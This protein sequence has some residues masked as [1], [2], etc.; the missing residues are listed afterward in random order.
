MINKLVSRFLPAAALVLLCGIIQVFAQSQTSTGQIT[1]VVSDGT[2]AVVPNATMTLTN[3]NT[4]KSATTT[5]N[6]T[7]IFQFVL[8]QPGTYTV[9]ASGGGFEEQTREVIVNVGRTVDVNFS[10]GVGDLT[11]VVNVTGEEIQTTRSEPDAVLNDTQISNLPINGRRFQDLATLTPTAQVDPSRGQ[12]SLSGQRGVNSNINVD[13]SDYSNPFFGGIRGGERSNSAFTVPQ[14]S[15]R[16]FNVIAAGYSA[17]FGRST[18]GVISVVTK[19][20]G[21]NLSGS[22]FYLLRPEQAARA[23]SYAKAIGDALVTQGISPGT[24]P[25][26]HQ[27][28]GSIGGPI[29]QDRVF[30]FGSYEQQKVSAPRQVLFRNALDVTPSTLTPGQRAVYDLFKSLEVPFTLTNDAIAGLGRVDA[31]INDTNTMNVRF[32]FSRNEGKNAVTTGEFDVDPTTNRSLLTNGTEKDRT[33]SLNGQLVSS[34]SATVINEFRA[35]YS[36]EVRPRLANSAVALISNTYG[37]IGTRSFMP[38]TQFDTRVQIAD[39]LTFL[40]NNHTLKAGFD[41]NR[42]HADQ[43]FGFDQFGTYSY[44]DSTDTRFL[45]VLSNIPNANALFGRFDRSNATFRQ[46]IGNLKVAYTVTEFAVFAQDSWRYNK[47]LTLNFGIRLDNQFNPTP[48]LGNTALIDAV[49]NGNYPIFAGSS[50]DPTEIPDSGLQFGPRVGFAW[51]PAGDGKTVVR[52]FSGVFYA[53]TPLLLMADPMNNFRTTPGNLTVQFPFTIPTQF[54]QAMFDAQNPGYV[55]LVGPGRSPNTVYRHFAI[56]GINLNSSPLTNMPG[57]TP[58]QL[59]TISAAILAASP[60]APTSALGFFTGAQ[61]TFMAPDF[62]NPMSL[63]FGGGVERQLSKA[64]SVGADFSQVRTTQLQRNKNINIP[65]AT[66]INAVSGRPIYNRNLR[67]VP[68]LGNISVRES[69]AQS[70]FR[71]LTLRA[72]FTN[73]W[74]RLN[75]FYVLSKSE[76]DDDNERDSGGFGYVDAFNYQPEYGPSRIDRRHQFTANP[77]FFLPYGFEISSAIKLRSGV[78]F[79]SQVGADLNSDNVNNDRPYTAFGVDLGR[80]AFRQPGVYEV[81]LRVQ[82]G[83]NFDD[84]KRLVLT[85]EFFNIFNSANIQ[86]GFNQTRYCNNS[87]AD[88]GLSG[89][90]NPNFKLIRDSSGNII[91][92]NFAGSQVFQAQFGARFQF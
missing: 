79:D 68:T 37:D 60:G 72:R 4:G 86:Y 16:E 30:Y 70:M 14:E 67:P 77:I 13:G 35:Q 59:Q 85:A 66:S 64:F 36:K 22:A 34:I 29:K 27:F 45:D 69:S 73:E 24:A 17:E 33:Y 71:A 61:P 12:I 75:A 62:K 31:V 52:G 88:C 51:D 3:K 74:L 32:N 21:N 89:I 41:F 18:G 1:G 43:S 9:A 90:T 44:F 92:S 6:S 19:S 47:N 58:A 25:T 87:N 82:K 76:S 48:E 56:L 5:T 81:D 50:M 65:V 91:T 54:N 26:Q 10:L 7:G 11:A 78:P 63:Q 83:F 15:V 38:T 80:N 40:V 84:R 39:S 8:V 28:G 53:R 2:G 46:Q 42:M 49:Q 20:G 55:G 57:L 23:H